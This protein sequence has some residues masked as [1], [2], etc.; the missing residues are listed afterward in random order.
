MNQ[1]TSNSPSSIAK[2]RAVQLAPT[3]PLCGEDEVTFTMTPH[4]FEYGTGDSSVELHVRLPVGQCGS[5]GFEF[6]DAEA[7]QLKHRA[8]CEHLGVLAPDE[9]QKVRKDHGMTR[10]QFARVTGLGEA[11]LNRWENG[12]S[13]Q[14]QANDR[15]LRLL[16]RPDNILRLEA[17]TERNRADPMVPKFRSVTVTDTLRA[18]QSAFCVR[19]IA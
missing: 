16:A 18:Q 19:L 13:I 6:L 8:I 14:S 12:L 9:I 1:S 7:E 5:C 2:L 4:A 10:A 17:F 3:C 15:Y 11:S